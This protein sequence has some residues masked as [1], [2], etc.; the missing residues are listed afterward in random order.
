MEPSVARAA[1]QKHDEQTQCQEMSVAHDSR[2]RR[3]LP[4]Y[5]QP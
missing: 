4:V 1:S 2:V 5:F 3:Q